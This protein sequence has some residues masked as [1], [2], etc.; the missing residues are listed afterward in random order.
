MANTAEKLEAEINIKSDPDEFFHSFGGKA[1]QLPNL[2]SEKLHAIDL[3]E[4]DWKT[5][6][7]VK[8][9][10]YVT[11]KQQRPT[12]YSILKFQLL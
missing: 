3:H 10:T 12:L 7:S 5:E 1:H 11:G 2:C 8:H 9:W 6:G 4:G